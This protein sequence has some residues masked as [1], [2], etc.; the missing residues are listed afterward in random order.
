MI[1]LK[2]QFQ[3]DYDEKSKL[4]FSV[5]QVATGG[6][7]VKDDIV[8][9]YEKDHLVVAIPGRILDLTK[10]KVTKVENCKTLCLNEARE[11]VQQLFVCK[12]NAKSNYVLLYLSGNT[13]IKTRT[14]FPGSLCFDIWF[15]IWRYEP[16]R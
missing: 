12:K 16:E 10:K 14:F 2:I 1:T 4:E 8:R 9:I 13:K 3:V 6:T 15:E 11:M 5:Y 7:N